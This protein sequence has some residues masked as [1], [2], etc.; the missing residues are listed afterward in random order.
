MPLP[1]RPD[2]GLVHD[3]CF[4]QGRQCSAEKNALRTGVPSVPAWADGALVISVEG[5]VGAGEALVLSDLRLL[6]CGAGPSSS[7]PRSVAARNRAAV[8]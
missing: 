2:G 4:G 8:V 7:T 6:S 3:V 1:R 5:E